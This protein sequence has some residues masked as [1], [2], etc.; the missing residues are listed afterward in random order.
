MKEGNRTKGRG[1]DKIVTQLCILPISHQ[2]CKCAAGKGRREF[3]DGWVKPVSEVQLAK[4][5]ATL[6]VCIRH[7]QAHHSLPQC[8]VCTVHSPPRPQHRSCQ[9][10]SILSYSLCGLSGLTASHASHCPRNLLPV[11]FHLPGFYPFLTWKALISDTESMQILTNIS[12]G[13]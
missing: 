5:T 12:V 2:F 8:S 1:L 9:P 11:T 7:Y 3:Q 6:E 10:P 13:H 4:T